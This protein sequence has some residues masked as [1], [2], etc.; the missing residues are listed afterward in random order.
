MYCYELLFTVT[1]AT[2]PREIRIPFIFWEFRG[3][4]F[5]TWSK[6]SS[7]KTFL[8]QEFHDY[9]EVHGRHSVFN[10]TPFTL[11]SFI[12][13]NGFYVSVPDV[14]LW[15]AFNGLLCHGT[16]RDKDRLGILKGHDP[17]ETYLW[18]FSGYNNSVWTWTPGRNEICSF[19]TRSKSSFGKTSFTNSS[20]FRES[21]YKHQLQCL[22]SSYCIRKEAVYP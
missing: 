21:C 1:Y 12:H 20:Y 10:V 11:W 5:S 18:E 14:L 19:S 8:N 9:L 15:V 4:S 13:T 3:Y 17:L 16:A 2:V 7:D 22:R 6:T